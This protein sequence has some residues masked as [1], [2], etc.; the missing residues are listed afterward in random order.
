MPRGGIEPPTRG[1]SIHRRY[2]KSMTYDALS[3][4]V[5]NFCKPLI[6]GHNRAGQV[7]QYSPHSFLSHVASV[8]ISDEDACHVDACVDEDVFEH[9]AFVVV[10][11]ATI[12]A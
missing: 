5:S 3:K 12:Y 7:Q 10:G 2:L 9:D 6:S 4:S 8:E 11:V 1:F